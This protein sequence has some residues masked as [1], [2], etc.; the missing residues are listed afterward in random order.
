MKI[1]TY[2]KLLILKIKDDDTIDKIYRKWS[3]IHISKLADQ[4][5]TQITKV[6]L[7]TQSKEC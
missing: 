1:N 3:L 2:S 6:Q 5:Q 4:T 7:L